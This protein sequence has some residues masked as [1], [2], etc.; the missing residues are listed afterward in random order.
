MKYEFQAEA[1]IFV[2]VSIFVYSFQVFIMS[3]HLL[4]L[5]IN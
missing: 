2:H 5:L 3:S 4:S 1:Q